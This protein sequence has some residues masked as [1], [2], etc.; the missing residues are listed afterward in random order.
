[1]FLFFG[2]R[3][4]MMGHLAGQEMNEI[5]EIGVCKGVNAQWMVKNLKF[6][7]FFLVDSWTA[8]EEKTLPFYFQAPESRNNV[9]EKYYGGSPYK[10]ETLDA[11]FHGVE[12]QFAGNDK[13]K[14]LRA[15]SAAASKEFADGSLDLIYIDAD[16]TYEAVLDDLFHW[17]SK[18]SKDGLIVMNDHT[19]NATGLPDY[20]VVQAL[21][22]FLRSKNDFMPLA[23]TAN[24]YAD[25]I[26]GRR[27]GNAAFVSSIMRAGN[28][29][30]LP[31]HLL[32]NFHLRTAS[33][34]SWLS[35]T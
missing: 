16:H 14:I 8:Y 19:L 28:I 24:N 32:S 20:G 4:Q 35:F 1:M 31:D 22:T 34:G 10:Q 3:H 2:D 29:L 17:E 7:K 25:V 33:G 9:V 30:E 12:K 26:I 23:L 5:A 11:L 18:L 6:Q 13:I 15:K 27:G 21:T